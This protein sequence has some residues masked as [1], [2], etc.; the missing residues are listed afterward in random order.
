[1][2][3]VHPGDFVHTYSPGLI[4]CLVKRIEKKRDLERDSKIQ[5]FK[6]K[7]NKKKRIEQKGVS[8]PPYTVDIMQVDAT[9]REQSKKRKEKGKENEKEKEKSTQPDSRRRHHNPRC[10]IAIDFL[11]TM[12]RMKSHSRQA[13]EIAV[14]IDLYAPILVKNLTIQRETTIILT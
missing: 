13:V 9:A 6:L 10:G 8:K 14:A 2:Y 1:M 12:Q 11:E 5:T 7:R 3:L 4:C